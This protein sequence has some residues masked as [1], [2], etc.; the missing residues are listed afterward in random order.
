MKVGE[1]F[2]DLGVKGSEKTLGLISGVKGGLQSTASEGLAAKAAIVGAMYALQNLFSTS[3]KAGTDLKNFNSV[4]GVSAQTLQQYQYAARQVGVSNEEVASSFSGL[5][6]TM[7]KVLLGK[8]GPAGLA[9][10]ARLTGDISPREIENLAKDPSA[11]IQKLQEYAQKEK[12][13]WLRNETLKTFGIS[14]GMIAALSRNAFTPQVLNAAPRY[15]DN[16]IDRLDKT[17]AK[18]SNL[19][20]KIEMAFGRFNAKHGDQLINDIDKITEKVIKLADAFMLVA[21]KLKIFELIG[22]VFE[23]WGLIFDSI[24][25]AT[26]DI[27]TLG[28]AAMKS[29]KVEDRGS[30]GQQLGGLWDMLTSVKAVETKTPAEELSSVMDVFKS[31]KWKEAF[32]SSNYRVLPPTP[33]MAPQSGGNTSNITVNQNQTFTH[34][35][36]DPVKAR[37]SQRNAVRDALRQMP[38]TTQGN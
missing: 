15:S 4:L 17:N 5:Q 38:A 1:L 11:L 36:T 13:I 31:G 30:P 8:G 25:A 34:D 32:N 20:T 16:E 33:I 10:V 14:E 22:K 21:E 3:N 29:R 26:D 24:S 35:G 37:T 2:L 27:S 23:G 28:D 9:E 12:N 6:S 18:W 19:G 7:G